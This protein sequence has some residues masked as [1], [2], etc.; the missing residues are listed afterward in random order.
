MVASSLAEAEQ[1]TVAERCAE[2]AALETELREAKKRASVAEAEASTAH[3]RASMA[4]E[5]ASASVLELEAQA[6]A[7]ATLRAERC[8]LQRQLEGSS[9]ALARAQD[10][11]DG[12]HDQVTKLQPPQF[13]QIGLGESGRSKRRYNQEDVDFL[14]NIFTQRSWRPSDVAK[15]LK[16]ADILGELF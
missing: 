4:D 1:A 11:L 7:G 5:R 8:E 15:A 3:A 2:I 9:S 6:A 16:K 13:S 14:H 10:K 12:L